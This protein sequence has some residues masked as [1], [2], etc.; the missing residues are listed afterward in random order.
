MNPS[1]ERDVRI[2]KVE[3]IREA[4]RNPYLDRCE[5]TCNIA[6]ARKLNVGANNIN[7]AGRLVLKRSFG[8][9][10]FATIQDFYDRIQIS[11]NKKN[12]DEENFKFFEKMIDVGD[13]I[14]VYGEIYRTEKGEL[15]LRVDK[16]EL[17]SKSIRPLPEKFHGITDLESR[18]RQRYLD[19]IMN[20]ETRSRFLKRTK[21]IN[22]IRKFLNDNDFVEVETPMLQVKPSGAL[23]KP[24]KTHHNA[25]DIDM[26]LR[27]APE[28]YL[29]RL[30]AGGFDRVYDMGRCFRNEGIDP[31]HLQEFT[32][33]EYYAA[34]WNYID[35]MNFTE[36]LIKQILLEV[37]GGLQLD[38]MGTKIDFDGEWPRTSFRDLILRHADIDI[39][40]YPEK[41]DLVKIIKEKKII[42][43]GVDFNR[44]GRGNL[45]DQLYKKVARP[46]MINPQ[47]LIHHPIDLSP[48]ARRNDNEPLIADR[49]QL[50]VNGWEVV[51]AY[52]ELIDPIDQRERLLKQ[53]AEREKGDEEAMIME[54]DFIICMEYGMPPI[55]GFG[56]GIDRFVALL[57]NQENL[58]E[59]VLFPLMRPIDSECETDK[60]DEPLDNAASKNDNCNFPKVDSKKSGDSTKLPPID[61]DDLGVE[62]DKLDKLFAEKIKKESLISHSIS[63]GAVMKGIAKKFGLNEQNYYYTGLLH[64]ID[65]DEIG[66]VMDKHGLIGGDWLSKLGVNE[67]VVQAIK[68]HNEE[69]N[70]TVRTNFIDFALTAAESLT[71]LIAATAKV[72]PDKKVAGVKPKSVVK[73]M[74][75]KLFAANVS[76]ENILLCEK[77]GLTL[78]EFVEIGVDSMKEVADQIGL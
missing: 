10:I 51:N 35:N 69:G 6:E 16:Y 71:G 33:V 46:K 25:L 18:S 14:S 4:G 21:L 7:L 60:K 57:T 47:F 43:E 68:S 11:L 72:Y 78:E 17:L 5:R 37:H 29:K 75:E 23:A 77:I 20:P 74:K 41:D 64:D 50:V 56:M 12:L 2:Q 40:Q 66:P 36:K 42:L 22:V 65:L 30:I 26:Y 76:R 31:S 52:S 19:L 28:T 63:S 62:Y 27:I 45:I 24:F 49:F 73:R 9:L 67:L 54:E 61:I 34:Y 1:D 58:R 32:M 8:K 38:Y 55:S 13:F 70:G 48:L 3:K 59:V 44:I 39:D 15:T 53:A